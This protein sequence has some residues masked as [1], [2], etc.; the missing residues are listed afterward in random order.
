[1]KL[2]SINVEDIQPND[3][4]SRVFLRGVE[5]VTMNEKIAEVIRENFLMW[6]LMT[7]CILNLHLNTM[8]ILGL[9]SE[10]GIMAYNQG[11]EYGAQLVLA[12]S[13]CADIGL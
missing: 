13:G 2:K 10:E 8:S 1:M 3:S 5:L 4:I 12:P 11:L 7:Q 6:F 9:A